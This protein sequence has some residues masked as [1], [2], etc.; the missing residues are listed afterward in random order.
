MPH[1]PG[2]VS[3]VMCFNCIRFVGER[4][5]TAR[6]LARLARTNTNLPGMK[7]WGYVTVGDADKIIATRAGMNAYETWRPLFGEVEERWRDRFGQS[8][9]DALSDSL[10][11]IGMQLEADLPDCMPIVAHGQR[12]SGEFALRTS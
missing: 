12:T 9:I 11:T 5:V 3:M 2:L 8:T 4:A 6:E 10:S 1:R 7:R